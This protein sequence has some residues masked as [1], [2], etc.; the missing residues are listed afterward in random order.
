MRCEPNNIDTELGIVDGELVLSGRPIEELARETPIYIY[1]MG[2]VEKNVETLL[3]I[4]GEAGAEAYYAVKA[5]SHPTLLKRLVGLGMGLETVSPGELEKALATGIDPG[6]II[7]NGIG[8][9]RRL[10]RRLVEMGVGKVN[11]DSEYEFREAVEA[12]VDD[13]GRIGVRLNMDISKDVLDTA[14]RTS[15][16]GVEP[17]ILYRLIE[18]YDVDR[19]G[20]HIHLGSQ[21]S[22]RGL[23]RRFMESVERVVDRLRSL[24]VRLSFLDIG[25]GL[26]KD[27]LWS[28]VPLPHMELDTKLFSPEICMH[29]YRGFLLR[30]R[31]V[32]CDA[33]LYIEPGRYVVGD[34]GILATRVVGMKERL[35]GTRWLILDAGFTHLL[36]G[37][38]YK[39]YFPLVNASRILDSHDTPY[40]VAGPLCD[41]DDVFHDYEGEKMGRPRLPRYRYLPR[42]TGIGDLLVFL[43][44]G[45]YNYEEASEYNSVPRPGVVFI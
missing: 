17:P 1:S 23:L 42:D 6:R 14:S 2:V 5:M 34:A 11:L 16:F 9:D 25:G 22:E 33:P 36:S 24:G 30:M 31:R 4:C 18:K 28:P 19:L 29:A 39:W 15:K 27:Y 38:L 8:K 20:I 41:S 10:I 21:I 40:R 35:D 43:H 32:V 12:G 7:Y 3:E 44:V 37:A 13:W 45:A 26:P